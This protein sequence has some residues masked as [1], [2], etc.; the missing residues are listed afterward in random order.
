MLSGKQLLEYHGYTFYNQRKLKNNM[1][2]TCTNYP[3]CKAYVR[4]NKNLDIV[5]EYINHSHAKKVLYKTKT[6]L[7]AR[8]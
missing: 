8:L 6:G 1:R 7:Y 3:T 2:W 5:S 4:T